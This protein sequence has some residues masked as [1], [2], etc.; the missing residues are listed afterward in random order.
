MMKELLGEVSEL[1]LREYA[2]A[3]KQHG[4]VNHS[5][6]ESYSILKEEC[7]EA[8]DECIQTELYLDRYW[9][10]IK[11]DD[12]QYQ[13]ENLK[14]I[15]HKS[16]LAAC[17]FIQTAAMATKALETIKQNELLGK[18]I[19]EALKHAKEEKRI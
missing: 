15:Q 2:R 18:K 10:S 11:Q 1:A 5:G 14:A 6:H 4:P 16:L 8:H 13:I 3:T 17:E 7:E 12:Y 19:Q 9:K